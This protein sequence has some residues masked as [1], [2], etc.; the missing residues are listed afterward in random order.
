MSIE[1]TQYQSIIPALQHM[2]TM[3]SVQSFINNPQSAVYF[4]SPFE[5]PRS[6]FIR[7]FP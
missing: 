1:L 5:Y 4:K 7:R 2:I 6:L 3:V